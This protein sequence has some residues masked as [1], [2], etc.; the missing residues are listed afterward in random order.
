MPKK[1]K[2]LT[3]TVKGNGNLADKLTI[4]LTKMLNEGRFKI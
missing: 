1:K 4:V 3:I 2:E